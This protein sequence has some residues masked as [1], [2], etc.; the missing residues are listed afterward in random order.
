MTKKLSTILRSSKLDYNNNNHR[1]PRMAIITM[2]MVMTITL[3]LGTTASVVTPVQ[4]Q[5][6]PP[7]DRIIIP[8]PDG[9]TGG[10]GSLIGSVNECFAKVPPQNHIALSNCIKAAIFD[11]DPIPPRPDPCTVFPEFC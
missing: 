3:L 11:D 5:I 2:M 1:R 8:E 6:P 4:A 10:D 9:D 7:L